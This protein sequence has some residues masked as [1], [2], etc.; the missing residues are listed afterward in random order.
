VTVEKSAYQ[1][2]IN[3]L[4]LG[5]SVAEF[6]NILDEA[7]VDTPIFSGFFNGNYDI[8][9]GQ[10]GAGKTA[11]FKLITENFQ[12]LFLARRDIV[13]LSGVNSSG[14]AIFQAYEERFSAFSEQQFENFW[15]LYFIVLFYNEFL[16]D[17][18]FKTKLR[19]CKKEIDIFKAAC[20]KAGIPD[21]PAKQKLGDMLSWIMHRF[22]RIDKVKA[23]FG[24]DSSNPQLILG[25][26]ELDMKDDDEPAAG[27]ST[28][29]FVNEISE[30]LN[31]ILKKCD[32]TMWIV[33][34][35]LDEV[36]RRYSIVEFNGLRGLLKAYRSFGSL[37][38]SNALKIKIFLRDDIMEFLTDSKVFKEHFPKQDIPPL[39]VATHIMAKASPVLSWSEEEI[40][41][42]VL[43]RLLLSDKMRA[44]IGMRADT[45]EQIDALL[46]TKEARLSYWNKIFPEKISKQTSLGWI[47]TRLRDSNRIVTPRS[48]IDMLQAATDYQK[49]EL[50]TEFKDSQYIFP[51]EAIK[52]GVIEASKKKLNDDV[53]N[54]FPK[55]QA[56]I[57][58]LK[59]SRLTKFSQQ[60]LQRIFGKNWQVTTETLRRIGILRNLKSSNDY[61]VEYLY[62]PALEMPYQFG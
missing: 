33:L 60:D 35:R 10:K 43:N 16:K 18:Q 40:E 58:K 57:E 41:K 24:T 6:D 32:Y 13:L 48:V 42:L 55:E 15:K 27:K 37:D 17:P 61:M 23:T 51:V 5:N 59:E 34:D 49:R 39:P 19:D 7:R 62:R 22:N 29:L 9:T 12:G 38:G 1:N 54:E 11:I 52:A 36:F 53:Y 25:G 46:S 2:I 31:N 8:V 3:S 26:L 20:V 21:I 28:A 4:K 56:N 45:R 47:Y 30:A 44:F 50:Q 14:E